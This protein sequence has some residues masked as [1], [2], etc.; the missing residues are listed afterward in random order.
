[1]ARPSRPY[2][3]G[4]SARQCALAFSRAPPDANRKHADQAWSG[5]I[6]VRVIR[7]TDRFPDLQ[8][9]AKPFK[10]RLSR[11]RRLIYAANY[12]FGLEGIHLSNGGYSIVELAFAKCRTRSSWDDWFA[13]FERPATDH[14]EAT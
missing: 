7:P 8:P 9:I 11:I 12:T 4:Q 13:H 14:E 3:P 5:Y 1:M 2:W 6:S 10:G